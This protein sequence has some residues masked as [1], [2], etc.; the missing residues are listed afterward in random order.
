MAGI[1]SKAAGDLENRKKCN[2][3]EFDEDLDIDSYEAFYRNLD[4]QI[5]RWWQIDPMCEPLEDSDEPGLE[6]LSP[7][8]SMA[9][10]PIKLSDPLGDW[11]DYPSL[12]QTIL[13]AANAF[14]SYNTFGV[15]LVDGNTQSSD[16]RLGQT[17]GH[18]AAA[19]TG[20]G[21]SIGV[22]GLELASGGTASPVAIPLAMHGAATASIATKRIINTIVN[23]L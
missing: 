2:G 1:S 19:I 4:P 9:N 22:G 5:G 21:V 3:I 15:G 20:A 11:P 14:A 6:S 13:G 10:N 12:G 7:Y 23:S 18:V 17:I 8:N 16:F